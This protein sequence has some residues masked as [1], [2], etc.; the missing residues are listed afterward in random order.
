MEAVVVHKL[1]IDANFTSTKVIQLVFNNS[2]GST[3]RWWEGAMTR[4]PLPL[5]CGDVKDLYNEVSS[6]IVS[7]SSSF[8]PPHKNN[9]SPKATV[10]CGIRCNGS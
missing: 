10:T 8:G 4:L 2:V 1:S 6:S 5:L 9:C 7:L 3:V